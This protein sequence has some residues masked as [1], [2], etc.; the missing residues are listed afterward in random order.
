MGNYHYLEVFMVKKA[1]QARPNNLLRAARKERGWTQKDVADRIGAP[2]SLNITRW[3][4]GTAFPSAHY[5]NQLC[6]LFGKSAR[7]LG[8]I[9]DEL[10]NMPEQD[11][12]VSDSKEQSSP[13]PQS[14]SYALS[15]PKAVLIIGLVLLIVIASSGLLYL[16]YHNKGVAYQVSSSKRSISTVNSDASGTAAI[17]TA[18]P[19]PYPPYSGKIAFYDPLSEPYL[20]RNE[21]NSSFGSTCQFMQGTY[22]ISEA[23]AERA[24]TCFNPDF[25]GGNFTIEVQM[26]IEQGDCGGIIV[27]S[28]EPKDY[29]FI[30]C[31]DGYYSFARYQNYT[32]SKLLVNKT[33][34]AIVVGLNQLNVIA[35][36]ANGSTFDL[37]VNKHKIDTIQDSSYAHGR[38]GLFA[39]ND[40]SSSTEVIYRDAKIWTL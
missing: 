5:V 12:L 19:D 34:P 10:P 40:T 39:S 35:I 36:V 13:L 6:S 21:T 4:R 26:K 20:W 11:E 14:T 17:A 37:Y 33:S 24:G 23:G 28:S 2:L 1:A 18:Y 22:H 3:E 25:D 27:R 7:E 30:V 31:Q 15:L 8:L 9:E 32:S 16:L 29:S 38:V